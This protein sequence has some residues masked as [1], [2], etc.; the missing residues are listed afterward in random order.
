[1]QFDIHPMA[2]KAPQF[3][4]T[5][6]DIDKAGF[7]CDYISDQYLLTTTFTEGMLQTAAG[8]R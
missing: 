8:T 2:R 6:R 1:M 7:D 4:K 5:I 3:I